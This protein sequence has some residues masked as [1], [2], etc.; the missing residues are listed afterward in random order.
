MTGAWRILSVD[1][2]GGYQEL[3]R[4]SNTFALELGVEWVV[5]Y[6]TTVNLEGSPPVTSSPGLEYQRDGD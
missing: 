3:S 5:Q 4:F 2:I 6:F 1:L